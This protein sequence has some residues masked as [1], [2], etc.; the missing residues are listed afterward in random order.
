[1][2]GQEGKDYILAVDGG[3]VPLILTTKE[4]Y[5]FYVE[6]RPCDYDWD[7]EDI[8]D[9]KNSK[10]MNVNESLADGCSNIRIV[11]SD[12]APITLQNTC[13]FCGKTHTIELDMDEEEFSDRLFNYRRGGEL[14]QRAFPMLDADQREFIKTGICPECWNS[15]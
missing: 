3:D 8:A 11:G 4:G 9:Y 14:I 7:E 6:V 12:E 5:C 1:M 15:L 2:E 10:P 13:P